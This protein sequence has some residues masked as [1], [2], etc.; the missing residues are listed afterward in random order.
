MK[1]IPL[2]MLPTFDKERNKNIAN[3][4][5]VTIVAPPE[6]TL[7]IIFKTPMVWMVQQILK[8]V[9]L[10]EVVSI[11]KHSV[12]VYPLQAGCASSDCPSIQ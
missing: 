9:R 8:H 4:V 3:Q 2:S 10:I 1:S 6:K 12:T 7:N 5:S 11:L